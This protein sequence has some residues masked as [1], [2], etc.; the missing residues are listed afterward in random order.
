MSGFKRSQEE[1]G[2]DGRVWRTCQSFTIKK[3]RDRVVTFRR[4][5]I[6]GFSFL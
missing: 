2:A 4:N 3:S 6:R 1:R 5:G